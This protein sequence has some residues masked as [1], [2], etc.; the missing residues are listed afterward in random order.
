MASSVSERRLRREHLHVLMDQSHVQSLLMSRP[1]NF[2]WYTGGGDNRVDRSAPTGEASVLVTR[3]AE[4]ILTNSIEAQRMRDEQTPDIPVLE[5]PWYGTWDLILGELVD[6]AL[7]GTDASTGIGRDVGTDIAPLRYVLDQGAIE[8][9]RNVG[10]DAARAVAEAA[11][12]MYSGIQEWEALSLLEAACRRSGLY[13]PVAMAAGDGRL[14]AYRHPIPHAGACKRRVML[15]VCAER[16]GLYANLT[17]W[18]HFE[19]P[20]GDLRERQHACDMIMGR[21][22]K[23]A[24]QTGLNLGDA[25][26]RCLGFYADAGYPDEWKLHHQGGL[27]GYASRELVARP[28]LKT[29]IERGQAFAWNP[30]ITGAK[31]E[32][33]FVLTPEGPEVLTVT[34][35]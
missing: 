20:D 33:T 14:R 24:T 2:A 18:V 13:T 16:G 34:D 12:D 15:V 35:R 25:F 23:E 30:S 11:S 17:R 8:R 27:T 32:E 3:D 19:E 9:Y 21:M 10:A 26:D 29:R 7:L 6:V 22:R 4:Y 1:A 28:G 31:A 5:Y